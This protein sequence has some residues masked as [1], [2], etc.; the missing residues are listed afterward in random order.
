[1]AHDVRIP[2]EEDR[3]QIARLLS[4]SLNSPLERSLARAPGLPLK[5]FRCAYEGDRVVAAAAE[6]HFLQWFGGRALP[7]SGI[8]AVAT[9][10][11]RRRSGLMSAALRRILEDARGRGDPISSLY[12]AV[13]RPYRRLGYELAGTFTQHQL[14]IDAIPSFAGEDLPD[15]ELADLE[16]DLDE[17]EQCYRSWVGARNGAIEPTGR[18]WWTDRVFNRPFDDT[19][20]VVVARGDARVE[21]FAAFVR[22]TAEGRLDVSFGL[23]CNVL[24]ATTDRALRAMLAYFRGHHGLGRWVRWVGPPNDPISLLVDEQH[25]EQ[26]YRFTWM[27]RLL[28]VQ[29]A[30]ERRGYPA[31]DGA[32]TIAVEDPLFPENGGPWRIEAASGKVAVTRV[33]GAPRP[34]SIGTLSALFTGYLRPADAVRLG[35][36]DADDP[37]V[38]VLSRLLAGPDPWCPF[39]F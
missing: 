22:E 20:R 34:V 1:M 32:C 18:R 3:E 23:D 24:V 17:I 33:G 12:P 37:A 36:L 39:F 31:E 8:F 35:L 21:G 7:M 9:L 25:V 16:H 13:L 30:F 4:T 27:T 15:V 29:A 11:E 14:P 19:F 38:D 28:D 6:F 5:D 2:Q 26:H 10:P